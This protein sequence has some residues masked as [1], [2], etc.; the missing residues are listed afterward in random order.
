MTHDAA[1]MTGDKVFPRCSPWEY[2]AA[3]MVSDALCV[4]YLPTSKFALI[5]NL[6]HS[7]QKQIFHPS[8]NRTIPWEAYCFIVYGDFN[9]TV[10]GRNFAP[11]GVGSLSH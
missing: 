11:V 7:L 1:M 10:D 8:S 5:M 9:G 3:C 6:S 4:G 2:L